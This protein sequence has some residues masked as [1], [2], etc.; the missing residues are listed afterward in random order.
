MLYLLDASVLITAKNT[1]YPL[2]RVPE[3][4]DWLVHQGE[5]GKVKIPR[6]IYEEITDGTDN[7]AKWARRDDVENA[8]VLDEEVGIE[9]VRTITGKGYATDLTDEELIKVGRDPFLIAYALIDPQNRQV[10]TVEVSKPS[11][12][13]ANRRI[14]DVC[15][16]FGIHPINTFDLMNTLDFHTTGWRD[17]EPD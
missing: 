2:D 4:W 5:L 16:D 1:Y 6:E 13:R 10:V 7:L 3:F 9:A 17:S 14:P 12:V 15:A 11:N 8:L